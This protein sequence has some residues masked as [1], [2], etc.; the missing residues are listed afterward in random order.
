MMR[1]VTTTMCLNGFL[2]NDPQFHF[3]ETDAALGPRYTF[4][5]ALKCSEF[6]KVTTDSRFTGS[7][8]SFDYSRTGH[9][10]N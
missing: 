1:W 4:L 2:D 6:Y 3:L 8:I 5:M 10:Q 9:A 7:N